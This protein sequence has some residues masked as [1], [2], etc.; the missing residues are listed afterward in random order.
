MEHICFFQVV[1]NP[2]CQS[3]PSASATKSQLAANLLDL[4]LILCQLKYF[5]LLFHMVP[6]KLSLLGEYFTLEL[7][8][9]LYTTNVRE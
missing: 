9:A 7:Q 5:F 6:Y 8:T 4:F 1:K 2:T 3:M